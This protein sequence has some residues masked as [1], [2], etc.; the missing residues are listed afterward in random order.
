VS[1]NIHCDDALP[2]QPAPADTTH[3]TIVTTN[4]SLLS[5]ISLPFI[6]R[7]N[8]VRATISFIVRRRHTALL[9]LIDNKTDADAAALDSHN[10]HRTVCLRASYLYDMYLPRASIENAKLVTEKNESINQL[11]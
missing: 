3:A 7:A 6:A 1:A 2:L 5:L 4:T 10:T 8:H 9:R 11:Q